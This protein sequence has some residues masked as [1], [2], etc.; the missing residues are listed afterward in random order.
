MSLTDVPA[1]IRTGVASLHVPPATSS[2]EI[3]CLVCGTTRGGLQISTGDIPQAFESVQPSWVPPAWQYIVRHPRCPDG[4]SIARLSGTFRLGKAWNSGANRAGFTY[5]SRLEVSRALWGMLLLPYVIVSNIVFILCGLPIGTSYSKALLSVALSVAEDRWCGRTSVSATGCPLFTRDPRVANL[6]PSSVV[7]GIRYVDD[8]LALSMSV[9]RDCLKDWRS[10]LYP[11]PV[12]ETGPATWCGYHVLAQGFGV[13]V[14]PAD[15]CRTYLSARNPP[16]PPYP[17][18]VDSVHTLRNLST[19]LGS[20]ISKLQTAAFSQS[21]VFMVLMEHIVVLWM[22]SYP[23]AFIRAALFRL[24]PASRAVRLARSTLA[25]ASG[26]GRG[27][28]RRRDVEHPRGGSNRGRR[29]SE[30]KDGRRASRGTRRRTGSRST[31]GTSDARDRSPGYK[32]YLAHQRQV[33]K[34]RKLQHQGEVIER[35]Q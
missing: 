6:A 16:S 15:K 34:D 20:R 4:L 2:G 22:M 7:L 11:T 28:W 14:L 13:S 33:K 12:N 18:F 10:W 24:P 19:A 23:L 17:P 8:V 35:A 9:C 30:G 32:A 26:M 3:L 29:S 27:E 5:W 31:S 1:R 21:I 25:R